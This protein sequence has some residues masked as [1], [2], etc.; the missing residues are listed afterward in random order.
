[1]KKRIPRRRGMREKTAGFSGEK[2][3]ALERKKDEGF[4]KEYEIVGILENGAMKSY[5][6]EGV[7]S[8]V[9]MTYS[10]VLS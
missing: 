4:L 9:S 1:R 8:V 10:A 5:S 7:A 3:D 2:N 6:N